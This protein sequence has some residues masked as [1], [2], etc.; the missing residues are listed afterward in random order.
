M[1]RWSD[2]IYVDDDDDVSWARE[3]RVLRHFYSRVSVEAHTLPPSIGCRSLLKREEMEKEKRSWFF[4]CVSRNSKETKNSMCIICEILAEESRTRVLAPSKSMLENWNPSKSRRVNAKASWWGKKSFRSSTARRSLF[5]V[6]FLVIIMP[7]ESNMC[8]GFTQIS[9]IFFHLLHTTA[10]RD[11][12]KEEKKSMIIECWARSL[13]VQL[14]AELERLWAD[15][16]ECGVANSSSSEKKKYKAKRAAA[17]KESKKNFDR[18]YSHDTTGGECNGT[19][20]P[21]S[22]PKKKHT[23]HTTLIKS[24]CAFLFRLLFRW[25]LPELLRVH[26]HTAQLSAQS[27]FFLVQPPKSSGRTTAP[28]I[29]D[30]WCVVLSSLCVLPIPPHHHQTSSSSSSGLDL[31]T[32]VCCLD[33]CLSFMNEISKVSGGRRTGWLK[34]CGNDLCMYS[35]LFFVHFSSSSSL[36]FFSSSASYFLT[37][38]SLHSS[39]SLLSLFPQLWHLHLELETS[40]HSVPAL[41]SHS[42]RSPSL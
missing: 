28:L 32:I 6:V 30:N 15:T 40:I 16:R 41:S 8:S 36:V 22:P 31:C 25:L 29:G 34:E 23:Q 35:L 12:K 3:K 18:I 14:R 19:R 11:E 39:S 33:V 13:R 24:L 4:C 26:Q 9:N 21:K 20:I 38:C 27:T 2:A 42:P 10:Q 1:S 37:V 5:C 7:M 17:W